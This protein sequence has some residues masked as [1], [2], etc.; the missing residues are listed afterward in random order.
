MKTSF[1]IIVGLCLILGGALYA[2]NALGVTN[3]SFSLDGWWTLFII[4]PALDAIFKK[5][6]DIWSWWVLSLGVL[7]L[8]ASR[9]VLP[10]SLSWTLAVSLLIICLGLKLLLGKKLFQKGAS[11][12]SFALFGGKSL[13]FAN[14]YVPALRVGA[15][16]GGVKCRLTEAEIGPEGRLNAFCLFGGADIYVP[17]GVNVKTQ[18]LSIFG[19]VTDKR[20]E[21]NSDLNARTLFINGL[22]IFGGIDIK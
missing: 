18:V 6:A 14:Q 7:L 20:E 12:G 19:G 4:L 11:Q 15:I 2:L 10:Y 13:D 8:L 17:E 21:K 3:I 1:R 9:E 5:K 16:F 22:C